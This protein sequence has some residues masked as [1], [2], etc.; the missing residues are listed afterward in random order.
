MDRLV[1]WLRLAMGTG[2]MERKFSKGE[3]SQAQVGKV[4]MA[5][6]IQNYG[7]K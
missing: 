6:E 1:T 2:E 7:R 5:E 3:N 4:L